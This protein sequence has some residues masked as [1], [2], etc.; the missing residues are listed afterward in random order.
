MCFAIFCKMIIYNFI[1]F[2]FIKKY[3]H[4]IKV[5]LNIRFSYL[6]RSMIL[7]MSSDGGKRKKRQEDEKELVGAVSS[8]N[9]K[10][11]GKNLMKL[12]ERE[13]VK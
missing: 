4:G 1:S 13:K 12:K 3:C 2:D 5:I 10:D 7:K 11:Q 6:F 8:D 9:D